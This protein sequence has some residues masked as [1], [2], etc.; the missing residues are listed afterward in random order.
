VGRRVSRKREKINI[1]LEFSKFRNKFDS[2]NPDELVESFINEITKGKYKGISALDISKFACEISR[3]LLNIGKHNQALL[4][5]EHAEKII[6][7]S[8]VQNEVALGRILGLRLIIKA[9]LGLYIDSIH[10]GESALELLRNSSENHEIG[11]IN[12]YLGKARF[13]CGDFIDSKRNLEDAISTFRRILNSEMAALS[14]NI[15]ARVCLFLGKWREAI[16]KLEQAIEFSKIIDRQDYVEAFARNIGIVQLQYGNW[17]DAEKKLIQTKH[18]K[19]RKNPLWRIRALLCLAFLE[20][21]KRNWVK[22]REILEVVLDISKKGNYLYELGCVYE[23]LGKMHYE[24]QE[25][26]RAIE[27]LNKGLEVGTNISPDSSL[28]LE[29]NRRLSQVY[30]RANQINKSY[31]CCQKALNLAKK[32]HDRREEGILHRVR[33][34]IH[35]AK[36]ERRVALRAFRESIKRLGQID[37]SFERGKTH[38][39]LGRALSQGNV[40]GK[41][42][43]F[44]SFAKAESLFERISAH[45]WS[46]V[47]KLETARLL[48]HQDEAERALGVLQSAR[49]IFRERNETEKLREVEE[50]LRAAEDKMVQTAIKAIGE[51]SLIEQFKESSTD[52]LGG[53]LA[54]IAKKISAERGFVAVREKE[55]GYRIKGVHRLQNS[56]AMELLAGLDITDR[57]DPARFM[58]FSTMDGKTKSSYMIVGFDLSEDMNGLVY[59]DRQNGKG[60]FRQE[61]LNSFAH[62]S[63]AI[64][65]KVAEHR[66][67]ELLRENIRL[68]RKLSE[69][70]GY[71]GIVTLSDRMIDILNIVEKIKDSPIPVLIE[72]ETG[73][74][75]ELVARAIHGSSRRSGNPFVP[76]NCANIPETLLESELFG[77]KRGAFTDAREDR[78]G[79]FEI[80]DG[81]TVFLDE[82]AEMGASVQA[83]LL[84]FLEQMEIVP[85]GSTVAKKID[86]RILAA[87]NRDIEKEV[88]ARRFREDLYY[89]L[90]GIRIHLPPLR[91]RKEDIPLLANHFL[92]VCSDE[93]GKPAKGFSNEAL[94]L[95]QDYPWPGNVRELA[96]EIRRAVAFLEH[97]TMV[98][99]R[100]LSISRKS[101]KGFNATESEDGKKPM[102][103]PALVSSFERQKIIRALENARWVKAKAARSLGIPE[104][105]LRSKLKKH[106]L[107][108]VSRSR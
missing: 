41:R 100:H 61:E 38:L 68:R 73:T 34:L 58:V 107:E 62:F 59:V 75:K 56:A 48:F 85:L 74:G 9:D 104:A 55:G 25:Y 60:P 108:R 7:K 87:T 106:G 78:R 71:Q 84:R 95:L 98:S 90:K 33:G 91:D 39:E 29:L 94:E 88:E 6:S 13:C 31:K 63:D 1:D 43:A 53:L 83:K 65:M 96:N 36:G 21:K 76:L 32:L 52:D 103:L 93:A 5:T 24:M 35:L 46:G 44:K 12:F 45:Y 105:T 67:R 18:L 57:H 16:D 66:Q 17:D 49:E 40:R 101:T 30:A 80:A 2:S 4:C 11:T 86:V 15:L 14:S 51:W 50:L 97:S 27:I 72:G 10:D 64:A 28:P 92:K 3:H 54:L 70:S 102:D 99:S 22:A 79:W 81:G 47:A 8:S 69:G 20:I 82:V 37:E 23:Y 77:H 42:E 26:K 19:E 89:R